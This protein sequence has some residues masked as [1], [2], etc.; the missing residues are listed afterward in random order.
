MNM[1]L[2][3]YH[4]APY[5]YFIKYRNGAANAYELFVA[6]PVTAGKTVTF[7]PSGST[8]DVVNNNVDIVIV[9]STGVTTPYVAKRYATIQLPA[10][11]DP[12]I[13]QIRIISREAGRNDWESI[14]SFRDADDI[15][16]LNAIQ[17]DGQTALNCP[18]VHM[19]GYFNRQDFHYPRMLI[20]R[21]GYDYTPDEDLER[22]DEELGTRL[23]NRTV[24]LTANAG[25][26]TL[27]WTSPTFLNDPNHEFN[28]PD[29]DGYY[30]GDVAYSG[31][32]SKRGRV[33]NN[34]HPV[35]PSVIIIEED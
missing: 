31:G 10:N 7:T 24:R 8:L 35:Q 15:V 11:F 30:V 5:Y 23:H 3:I 19:H 33:K 22:P 26:T 18:Y 13:A 12:A 21:K 28:D 9:V 20:A 17:I 2:Q 4:G 25:H 34:Q 32:G 1:A 14:L 29:D 6:V 27:T 16:A